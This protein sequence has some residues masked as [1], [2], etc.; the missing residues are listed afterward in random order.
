MTWTVYVIAEKDEPRLKIG[1]AQNVV[2]RRASL[3]VGNSRKLLIFN[4]WDFATKE[5]A[6]ETEKFLHKSYSKYRCVGE[7]FELDWDTYQEMCGVAFERFKKAFLV[8]EPW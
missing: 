6:L 2:K 7:W 4:R 3:Q 1:I 8:K 5:D